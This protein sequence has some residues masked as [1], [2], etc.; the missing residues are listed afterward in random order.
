VGASYNATLNLLFIGFDQG[1]FGQY[2]IALIS[3]LNTDSVAIGSPADCLVNV[4]IDTSLQFVCGG[5]MVSDSAVAQ[6][7]FTRLELRAD[8]KV[9]GDVTGRAE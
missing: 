5:S 6:V 3:V 9:S 8:G 2:P 7:T 1:Q 4:A